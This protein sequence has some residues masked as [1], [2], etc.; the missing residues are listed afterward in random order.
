[1]NAVKEFKVVGDYKIWIHFQDGY[2]GTID[3]KPLL[4]TGIALELLAIDAFAKVSIELGGGLA[5][6]N[7]FDVC[8]NSLQEL[9]EAKMHA[10]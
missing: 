3:F 1:M 10:A 9:A 8:P 6:E 2:Q 5:W 7:G 4:K